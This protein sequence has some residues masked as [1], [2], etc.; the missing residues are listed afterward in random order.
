MSLAQGQL[1]IKPDSAGDTYVRYRFTPL[2]GTTW[3]ID[4]LYVDPRF[5]S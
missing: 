5:R 1:N 3:R 2:Y 4:D